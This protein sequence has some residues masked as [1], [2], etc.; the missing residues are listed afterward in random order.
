MTLQEDIQLVPGDYA[1][2]LDLIAKIRG[3]KSAEKFFEDLPDQM[4][5]LHTYSALL[6][7]YVQN[8]LVDKAEALVEKMSECG[9][10]KSQIPYNHMLSLYITNGKLEKVPEIIQELKKNTSPD[11]V[12]F[13]LWLT[14]CAS[15]N[16]VETAERVFL[17]QKEAKIDPDW[18]T[19]SALTNL[20]IKN[21]FPEKAASTLKEMESKA[22][23]RTRAA[24]TSL[25]SLHTNMGNKDDVN[26]IWKKMKELYR[27]MNDAEYT[28]MISSLVK[29]G[30]FVG[31]QNL[32]NEWESISTT[33]DVRVSNI[34]LASYINRDQMEMAANF[35]N[36]R[37]QKGFTP[38]YTTWE[39]FTWGYLK[40]KD[41]EKV[42]DCFQ[43]AIASVKVWNPDKEL[44]RE[45]YK[46]LGD[47]A[48]IE[49]AEQLLIILRKAGHLN[50]EVYNLLLKTYA[51]AG[52]MPPT[53]AERMKEDNVQLD[54]ETHRL[55][56][57]TSKMC[58]ADVSIILS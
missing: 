40:Q 42:L 46:M 57:I 25:L 8:N 31:A 4:R 41:A 7:V 50:T 54:G 6:H 9:L 35:F 26:R 17:E 47:Q 23:R 51:K 2:H 29:L 45:M 39:L 11:V 16:D 56:D 55:L 38:C 13:S 19:Y 30:D 12:T 48:H 20:Y 5:G 43:K 58:V 1:V 27:N 18:V 15:L 22:S 53:V 44:V 37:V 28:C 52:K 36:E 34:V 10:L 32:Y 14:F 49:G 24:Y 33:K 21:A 3:L